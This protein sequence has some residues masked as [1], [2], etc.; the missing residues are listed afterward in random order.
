[1]NPAPWALR[2]LRKGSLNELRNLFPLC[3]VDTVRGL[4]RSPSPLQDQAA[5]HEELQR[6]MHIIDDPFDPLALEP[7][8]RNPVEG[9]LGVRVSDKVPEDISGGS[10]LFPGI[11]G[12]PDRNVVRDVVEVSCYC[13]RQSHF[14]FI[15]HCTPDASRPLR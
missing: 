5:P 10:Q 2:F 12:R 13:L 15:S 7:P 14:P 6:L 1:M 4:P 11:H 3:W 8:L 9:V